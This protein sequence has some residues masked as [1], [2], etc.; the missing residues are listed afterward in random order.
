MQEPKTPNPQIAPIALQR[1]GA[2]PRSSRPLRAMRSRHLEAHAVAWL[3]SLRDR[4]GGRSR[5]T[6]TTTPSG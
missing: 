4:D 5:S 1:A 3:R 2:K 6:D